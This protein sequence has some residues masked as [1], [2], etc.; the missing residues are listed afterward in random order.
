MER[1]TADPQQDVRM[2]VQLQFV[3][4]QRIGGEDLCDLRDGVCGVPV[5]ACLQQDP[6]QCLAGS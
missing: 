6:L 1:L 5:T 2:H 4:E 3:A